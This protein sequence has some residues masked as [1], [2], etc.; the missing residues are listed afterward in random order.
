MT[1]LVSDV[2]GTNTRIALCETDGIPRDIAR[3]ANDEFS[4]FEAC[5]AAYLATRRVGEVTAACV[6]VAGPVTSHRARLTNRNWTFELDQ[7]AQVLPGSG[8]A[9][10]QLINDLVALGQSL[11]GLRNDQVDLIRPALGT[12]PSN[13]QSLVVGLGTGFN[14]C[15]AKEGD[16]GLTVIGAELGHA[17]LP[18]SVRD[19]LH[20]VI[21]PEARRFAT[22]EDLFSGRGVSDLHRVI[23]GGCSDPSHDIA[24]AASQGKARET[25]DLLMRLLGIFSRELVFQYLPLAGM[26]FAGGVARGALGAQTQATFL[27]AFDVPGPFAD[28]VAQVP[29]RLITDDGA[30]LTG[31]ARVA[32][33]LP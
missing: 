33:A 3:F 23:T 5:L 15:L 6:A 27:S 31:A 7:I 22:A 14:V 11:P 4:S 8:T 18:I 26:Y 24:A 9:K 29:V 13:G 20:D 25:V 21:G 12:G 1:I 28:L 10:V 30:A 16:A 32:V 2:G 17:S 19:T